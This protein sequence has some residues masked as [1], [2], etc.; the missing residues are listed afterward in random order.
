M[1]PVL[2]SAG[3]SGAVVAVIF[4]WLSFLQRRVGEHAE[5][6]ARLEGRYENERNEQQ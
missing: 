2:L 6:I 3:L 1:W 4:R 5:R